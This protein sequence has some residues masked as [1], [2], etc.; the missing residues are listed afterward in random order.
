[1]QDHRAAWLMM[2]RSEIT[3]GRFIIIAGLASC[4]SARH[5]QHEGTD[6]HSS[7]K[8]NTW[9]AAP[10]HPLSLAAAP[11]LARQKGGPAD[12]ARI[13]SGSSQKRLAGRTSRSSAWNTRFR[14]LLLRLTP[15]GKERGRCGALTLLDACKVLGLLG[16]RLA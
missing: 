14:A 4:A 1:M 13:S 12:P 3:S 9:L 2:S 6:T 5:E 15:G 8:P 11:C 16:P 10:I 7:T